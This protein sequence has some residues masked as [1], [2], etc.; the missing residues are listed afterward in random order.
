V[1]DNRQ[2]KEAIDRL[3]RRFVRASMRRSG[4]S[5]T[6]G[7]V[8]FIK[9][10]GGDHSEWAWNPPGASERNIDPDYKFNAKNLEPLARTLRSIVMALGHIQT[11][12][13]TFTK[14]R[15]QSVSPDGN[16]GGKGFVMPIKDIR[17]QLSNCDE[18]LSSIV[19]TL[20]DE[21][22]A[23]HWHPAVDDSGGDPRARDE[24]KQIMDDVEDIKDDPEEWAEA[25][26][27]E[28]D[29]EGS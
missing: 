20:D 15:S 4:R 19:D 26:E 28:M 5:K 14:I 18:A 27:A 25:E 3:A 17:K 10:R 12:R 8:R 7:E 9:D 29:E 6:A 24:V 13:T 23:V 22:K 16:L 1:T 21:I 11:A 2:M